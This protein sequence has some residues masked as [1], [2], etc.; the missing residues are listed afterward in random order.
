MP[1]NQ[2][3]SLPGNKLEDA[4]A[5]VATEAGKE[6][7]H[8]VSALMGGQ[9]AVWLATRKA[10]ADAA[11]MAIETQAINN[12]DQMLAANRRQLEIDASTPYYPAW[13]RAGTRTGKSGVD[14]DTRAR[15]CREERGKG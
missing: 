3:P 11:Q 15:I 4:A 14:H 8:G 5:E 7:V 2:L 1:D 9:M 13:P 12:R 6:I 10:K